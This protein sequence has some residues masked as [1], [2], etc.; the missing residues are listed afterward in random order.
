MLRAFSG[1]RSR[2]AVVA[3]F[4][5]RANGQ[6]QLVDA[7]GLDKRAKQNRAAFAE[8]LPE[9]ALGERVEQIPTS[10]LSP[11]TRRCR[12]RGNALTVLPGAWVKT[13]E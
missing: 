6:A 7:G 2:F 10:G 12:P 9:P 5:R 1:Y 13:G 11:S 3:D 8:H 4:D